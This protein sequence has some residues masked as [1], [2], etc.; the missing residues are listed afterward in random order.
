MDR[1]FTR[2][3]FIRTGGG[4][5]AAASLGVVEGVGRRAAMADVQTV[6]AKKRSIRKAIKLGMVAGELT[7]LEKFT[8]VKDLG[9]D[10]IEPDSPN[11]LDPDELITARDA[12][13]LVIHGV[14]D[15]VHWRDTLSHPDSEVRARG[16][17]GLETALRDAQLYGASTVL[18]VPAVV[19]EHVS[20]A[21]AYTRS[22]AEIR[23]IL[24][25]AEELGIKIA[26]ENVWNN[27]LLSPLEAA[28]YVD[29]LESPNV[30]WYFDVGNIVNYGWPEQW[31]R[32]LGKRIL[33]LDI[34]EFSR[35][36]RN[37]EGLWKGFS[38]E[39]LEGDCNW[40][41]VMKALDEIGYDGWATAEVGGGGA[42]RLADIAER[43]DRI[44][45]L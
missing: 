7:L 2:R 26:I 43:M 18:L 34:K 1:S 20:Y 24:P 17:R 11:N 23:K 16:L 32:I 45:A 6:P 35:S 14:V 9:F 36:K 10:G 4:V 13:G 8:L 44:F 40:P 38:V 22:Q 15:S 28:R 27:F 42:E 12:T 21:D 25:L 29:E 30:G 5:I 39:L 19:N 33:K 3:D 37:D 31:V 41:E